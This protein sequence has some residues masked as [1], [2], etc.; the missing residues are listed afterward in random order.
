MRNGW[1]TSI[2]IK[3]E[4][5]AV[6]FTLAVGSSKPRADIVIFSGNRSE[7]SQENINIIIECKREN[8]E[9]TSKKDGIG[10]LRSYM[11]ACLNC[12]WG[13]WTNGKNKEVFRKITNEKGGIEFIEYNDIPSFD[14]RLED[15][16]RPKRNTLKNAVEDNLLFVFRICHNHIYVTD[17]MQKQ[18]AFFELLKVIFCK[19]EDERNL[20]H[21][22]E[23]YATSSERSN[24]D[25]QLT[26]Q[27]R[28][29]KIFDRVKNKHPR[30]F[31]PND[32]IKLKPRSLAY[33][34]SE[35]QKYSLLNT[36]IDIKG[37]T[38]KSLSGLIYG[39]TVENSLRR[40]MLCT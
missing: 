14:G 1:L 6:E 17:G 31:D 34:V 40:V 29:G 16:D 36:H 13:L 9:V 35:I 7:Q 19:I 4:K 20:G 15:I 30:I 8:V 37:K 26:V 27:K 24:P 12:E 11:A 32:E 10:Q 28:I 5:I 39:V 3:R 23:F 21:P 22:L 25:G 2:S 18:P 38:M 33:I